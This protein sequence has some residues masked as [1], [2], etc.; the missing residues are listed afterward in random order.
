[1][2]KV[3]FGLFCLLL[4]VGCG[5]TNTHSTQ[6]TVNEEENKV[7]LDKNSFNFSLKTS[8]YNKENNSLHIEYETGLP[9]GTIVDLV[10]HPS[11]P[12]SWGEQYN[13]FFEYTQR[14]NQ[15]VETIVEDGLIS[16]TF[17]DSNFKGLLLPNSHFYITFSVPVTEQENTFILNEIKTEEEFK[18]KYPDIVK[19]EEENQEITYLFL[20]NEDGYELKF[21]DDYEM[22][23]AHAIE[24]IYA[25][26]KKETI[27]YKELEKNPL[28]YKGTP[29][30]FTGTVLQ[31]QEEEEDVNK[32]NTV[33]R[34]AING[35]VN[36]VVYV[37]FSNSFGMEGVVS[38]DTVT[39]YGEITGSTTYESVAGYKITIPSMDAVVYTK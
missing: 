23:N 1:M 14:L 18:R 15:K 31:I 24:D 2:K 34:L 17:D 9:D 33:L 25:H 13:P 10:L 19:L 22:K 39:V 27:S 29:I 5:T 12:D 28:K 32:V 30:S 38:E 3:I 7:S 4:M 6:S 37:T 36:Q 16:H 21:Y 8:E 20:E 35:D 11:H 26:Y